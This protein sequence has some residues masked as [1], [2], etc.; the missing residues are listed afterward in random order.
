[1]S[2]PAVP[3]EQLHSPLFAALLKTVDQALQME[4]AS[5]ETGLTPDQRDRIRR[6]VTNCLVFGHPDGLHGGLR[7][8]IDS[9]R[10]IMTEQPL[11]RPWLSEIFSGEISGTELRP[12]GPSAER[13]DTP[14]LRKAFKGQIPDVPGGYGS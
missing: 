5:P 14:A 8:G 11:A 4:L 7:A 10:R 6:R 12:R 9:L 2:E 3:P 1:M 13:V